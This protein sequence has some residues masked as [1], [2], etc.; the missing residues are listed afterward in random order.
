VPVCTRA[1]PRVSFRTHECT[2]PRPH[3]CGQTTLNF[4][5]TIQY[6]RYLDEYP[7]SSVTISQSFDDVVPVALG[8]SVAEGVDASRP[9][10][11]ASLHAHSAQGV[12]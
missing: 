11:D 8:A 1:Q 2:L 10:L 12:S 4:V 3:A 7:Y 5:E 6:E 9:K